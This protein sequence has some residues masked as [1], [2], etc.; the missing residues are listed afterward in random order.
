MKPKTD[1]ISGTKNIPKPYLEHG[2]SWANF[3]VSP[4]LK[5]DQE[6]YPY[7][8]FAILA[9]NT[10]VSFIPPLFYLS[11]NVH[12]MSPQTLVFLIY[13]KNCIIHFRD[14]TMFRRRIMGE[15]W[16]YRFVERLCG[17]WEG[18]ITGSI[19][20]RDLEML[21]WFILVIIDEICHHIYNMVHIFVRN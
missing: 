6:I 11:V 7:F 12:L 3:H 4:C 8:I 10:I 5:K 20:A 21:V 17:G 16:G 15:I 19:C 9:G 13:F 2:I 1:T 18:M 14:L